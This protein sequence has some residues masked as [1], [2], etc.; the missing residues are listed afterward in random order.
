MTT[1]SS[2]EPGFIRIGSRLLEYIGALLLFAMMMLTFVD[3]IARYF[4]SRS[5][6]GGFEITEIMLATLIFCGLPLITLR[7]GHITVDLLEGFFGNT[8]KLLRDRLVYI[9]VTVTLAFL[10][11]R[12]WLKGQTFVEY[13]DQTAILYIPLAP[14]C[15][16]MSVLCI[17]SAA[18]AA[19]FAISGHSPR[20]GLAEQSALPT[21]SA[22]AAKDS[23]ENAQ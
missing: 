9:M 14:V 1:P 22:D 7:D 15:F 21:A 18:I 19:Y 11:Y 10:G 17:I 6:T 16:I 3:V 4:F 12:L 2:S 20:K 5:I 8:F 23:K 13:N